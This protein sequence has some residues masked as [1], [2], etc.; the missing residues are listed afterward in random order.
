MVLA[1]KWK[2]TLKILAALGCSA[3]SFEETVKT[4]LWKYMLY[5]S[6]LCYICGH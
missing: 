2:Q 1:E 4:R 5:N 3:L 6:I